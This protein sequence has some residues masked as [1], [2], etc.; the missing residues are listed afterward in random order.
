MVVGAGNGLVDYD[1]ITRPLDKIHLS[2]AHFADV[3]L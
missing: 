1:V 3:I 2:W